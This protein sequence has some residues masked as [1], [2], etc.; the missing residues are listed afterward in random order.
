LLA[1]SLSAL[2]AHAACPNAAACFGC[3]WGANRAGVI[4]W[5]GSTRPCVHLLPH[6]LCFLLQQHGGL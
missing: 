1:A 3:S 2:L 4:A 5:S 6:S